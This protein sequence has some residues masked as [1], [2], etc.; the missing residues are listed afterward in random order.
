MG[1]TQNILFCTTLQFIA[2]T[3]LLFELII[4]PRV[5]QAIIRC[6]PYKLLLEFLDGGG[7]MQDNQDVL[8]R[9]SVCVQSMPKVG[10]PSG[11]DDKFVCFL[12][13]FFRLVF[14][15]DLVLHCAKSCA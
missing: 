14:K 7:L 4:S 15:T 12:T 1:D 2:L 5:V 11:N 8:E 10:R 9:Y 3:L 6:A 13:K